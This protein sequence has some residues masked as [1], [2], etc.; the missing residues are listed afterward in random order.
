MDRIEGQVRDSE[1]LAKRVLSWITCAKRPLTTLGL[2][3][4]FGVE[5]GEPELDNENLPEVE[6]IVSVC[7]GLVTVDEQGNTIRLVHYT[8][9]EFFK[10]T[11][12]RWF[13][14]AEAD[15]INVCI[16]YLSFDTFAPGFCQ[17]D[18]EFEARLQS[19]PLY[20]YAAQNWGHHIRE[21]NAHCP[22][23]ELLENEAKVSASS[24]ALM[25]TK[26]YRYR[27]YSQEVPRKIKG[28][29]LAAWFGLTKIVD[30]LIE[31]GHTS[32]CKDSYGRTPLSRAAE[33][34]H[35]AVVKLL[36]ERGAEL[37]SKD[38]YDWTPL[39]RAAENGHGA[40]V[41]LLLERGA[42]LESK[43][44]YGRTPLSRAAEHG[45]EAVVKL[46]SSMT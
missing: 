40:V 18:K 2:Q 39:S 5:I 45:H 16:S 9:Q 28:I 20:D 15:I 34:G 12:R 35:E 26:E 1:I 10:R 4:A 31:K 32:D 37:E 27:D 36:L 6:Y 33:R 43:D 38:N 21:S 46:L 30:W 42:E 25:V 19:N 7:A 22:N 11:Q 14:E 23:T 24:Q 17:S 13:P 44:S 29:H 8:A 41:K 3:H